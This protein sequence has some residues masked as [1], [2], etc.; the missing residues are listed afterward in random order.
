MTLYSDSA[1]RTKRVR[2]LYADSTS[3]DDNNDGRTLSTPAVELATD[4]LL[5]KAV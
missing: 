1:T 2:H 5:A 3:G 4:R